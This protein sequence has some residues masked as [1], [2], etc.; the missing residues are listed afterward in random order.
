MHANYTLERFSCYG[1]T[2]NSNTSPVAF[3]ILFGNENTSTWIQFW[4]YCLDLH[5]CV[6]SGKITILTGQ[7]KGRKNAIS[8]Y[9]RSVGHFHCSYHRCQN[10]IKMCGGGGG[11]IPNSALWI[12]NK[13]MRCHSVA[14]IDHNKCEHLKAMK[15]KDIQYLNSLT[16]ESHYLAARCAMGDN[17]YMYHHSSSGVVESMNMANSKMRACTAVDVPNA[18]ILFNKMKQETWGNKSIPT[19]WGKEE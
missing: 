1:V 2:A 18:T 6:D 5:S 8:G 11:K 17:I 19:P 12:Y 14:L 16:N 3:A 13:L 10:I 4:K 7:D 15:S 9:L